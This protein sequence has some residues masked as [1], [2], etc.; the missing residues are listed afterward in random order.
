MSAK[1]MAAAAVVL[2]TAAIAR[3]EDRRPPEPTPEQVADIRAA[4][5]K[6]G[7][8]FDG[9]LGSAGSRYGR[10]TLNRATDDTLRELPKI[11]FAFH[12]SLGPKVTEDSLAELKRFP[13]LVGLSLRGANWTGRR[14]KDLA[15]LD[16]LVELNLEITP[17][18]EDVDW[19]PLRQLRSLS[20]GGGKATGVGLD[21]L[22]ELRVLYLH[23]CKVDE[24][25]LRDIGRLKHL[26]RLVLD[27]S[28]VSDEGLKELAGLENL[29]ELNLE[30]TP[31]TGAGFKDIAGL[32]KLSTLFLDRSSVT[33][34][35][36]KGI[37]TLTG[38]T[39]L[40]LNWTKVTNDGV[41]ELAALT[42]LKSLH[43]HETDVT[44]AGVRGLEKALPECTIFVKPQPR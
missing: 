42:R 44:H 23:G 20:I 10:V 43:L 21:Q 3:T 5:E 24:A 37:K 22:P 14:W 39:D 29:V 13:S 26:T 18:V 41:S 33:D 1:W 38:L 2:I 6:L 40:R 25:G 9:P 31:V 35:G 27:S 16:N 4:V 15:G 34:E 28:P 17:N 11:S 8:R 32:K 30:S 19:K 12:L 36:L 7:G